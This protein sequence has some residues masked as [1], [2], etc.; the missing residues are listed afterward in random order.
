MTV[1]ILIPYNFTMNDE[2]S[3]DF[4]GH[5]YAG[6]EDVDIT[7]FHAFILVPEI[8]TRNNPIMDKMTRN[9]SYLRQQQDEQ[10]NALEEARQKLMD[11]GFAGQHIHCRYI[12]IRQDI[13]RDIIWLWKTEK[14][15]VVVLN[16]N[17][18]NIINYFSRSISKRVTRHVEGGIGVHIVN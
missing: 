8:D 13:A 11:Y 18:G 16:R 5:R 7:L 1:K 15:D 14:F 2:K 4:V 17:P 6:K 12:P 9:T 3:I 10:K